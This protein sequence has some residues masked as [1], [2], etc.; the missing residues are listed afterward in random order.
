MGLLAGIGAW[1]A[2]KTVPV[3]MLA[4]LFLVGLTTGIYLANSATVSKL[5]ANQDKKAEAVAGKVTEQHTAAVK[6][7]A[8]RKKREE[9]VDKQAGKVN[10]SIDDLPIDK[11]C[12]VPASFFKMLNGVGQ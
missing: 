4:L 9:G 12:K 2:K 5:I 1:V 3:W 6:D 10:A 8:N 7:T 11:N